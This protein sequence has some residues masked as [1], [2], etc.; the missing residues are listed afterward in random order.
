MATTK[1]GVLTSGGDASGMNAA[2]RAIVRT[3]LDRGLEVWAVCE[4][5]RGLIEGGDRIR[6]LTLVGRRRHH[7]TRRHRDRIGAVRG[8]PHAGG[9]PEGR[10]EHVAARHRQPGGRGRRRVADRSGRA[11]WRV[12]GV[13]RG[14]GGP[15]RGRRRGRGPASAADRGR[16]GRLDRQ[17]RRRHRHDDRRRHGAPPHH[18]GDRRHRQHGLESPARLHRRGHGPALRLPRAD[19]RDGDGRRRPV[20]PRVPACGRG[21]GVGAARHC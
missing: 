9:P 17:R 15:S 4:G 2:V 12:A 3:G 21:L 7:P 6:P 11:A 19:G 20:H 18:R 13:R 14:T 1:I 8:V 5:Y 16:P 10:P